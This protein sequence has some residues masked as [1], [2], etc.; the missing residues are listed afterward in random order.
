MIFHE[1]LLNGSYTESIPLV[2]WF[3]Q[4]KDASIFS[5]KDSNQIY[6]LQCSSLMEIK[7]LTMDQF[8]FLLDDLQEHLIF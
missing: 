6:Q 5:T 3:S 4:K 2:R 1:V 7:K 8:E